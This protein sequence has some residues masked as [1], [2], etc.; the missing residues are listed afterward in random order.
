MKTMNYFE[1]LAYLE[2]LGDE[3]KKEAASSSSLKAI[4][5]VAGAKP[6]RILTREK[7]LSELHRY[8][9]KRIRSENVGLEKGIRKRQ[10]SRGEKVTGLGWELK[11]PHHGAPS[12]E[13]YGR[14]PLRMAEDFPPHR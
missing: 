3:L 14:L 11:R 8:R 1:K 12:A 6:G 9:A 10:R 4:K 7:G 5:A 13:I 2:D